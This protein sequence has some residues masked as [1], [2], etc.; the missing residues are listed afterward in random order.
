MSAMKDAVR[1]IAGSTVDWD[2]HKLVAIL[3]TWKKGEKH[4]DED[5]RKLQEMGAMDILSKMLSR[6]TAPVQTRKQSL[7]YK[8]L[9]KSERITQDEGIDL[10]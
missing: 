4:W 10:G 9:D 2:Y 3:R 6:E 5:I 8:A 1:T 7:F